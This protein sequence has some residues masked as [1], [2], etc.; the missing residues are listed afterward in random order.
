MTPHEDD[1]PNLD[2]AQQQAEQSRRQAEQE[3]K[4][5]RERARRTLTVAERLRRLRLENH[6]SE[7]FDRALGGGHG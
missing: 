2:E 3:L 6:F 5:A 1:R 7:L 4:A